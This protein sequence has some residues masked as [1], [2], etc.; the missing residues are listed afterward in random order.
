MFPGPPSAVSII[1]VANTN[2]DGTQISGLAARAH[3]AQARIGGCG[4]T[5]GTKRGEKSKSR[6]FSARQRIESMHWYDGHA[7]SMQKH[8]DSWTRSVVVPR[9]LDLL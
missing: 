2:C 1:D 9:G 8:Y 6:A 3:N 4:H 5:S 7:T